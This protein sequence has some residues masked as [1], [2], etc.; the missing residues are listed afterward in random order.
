MGKHMKNCGVIYIASGKAYLE[1][2]KISAISVKKH[3][4]DMPIAIFTDDRSIK[5]DRYFDTVI[6]RE[7]PSHCS[8]KIDPLVDSPFEKTLFLDTDTYVCHPIDDLFRA[9][10]KFDLLVAHAPNRLPYV[11]DCPDCL[12]ELNT[13]VIAFRKNEKTNEFFQDWRTR[14]EA[15]LFSENKPHHDQHAFREALFYNDLR[16]LILPSEYNF[17]PGFPG[18]I[19]K[20][21][22]VRIIHSREDNFST[23]QQVLESNKGYR[24]TCNQAKDV[25]DSL[26]I[27]HGERTKKLHSYVQRILH[28]LY[29]WLDKKR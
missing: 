18:Y 26:L 25:H 24:I 2:A 19:G 11:V 28:A 15:Q 23:L 14:Y 16:F 17:R 8:S 6:Y 13:G 7:L 21:T 10:D 1:E 22:Q 3:H 29:L 5:E 9:L 27:L 4:P 20:N 12:T